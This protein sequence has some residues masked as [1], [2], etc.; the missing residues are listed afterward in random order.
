MF[1]HTRVIPIRL[2]RFRFAS[3]SPLRVT[4]FLKTFSIEPLGYGREMLPLHPKKNNP[5]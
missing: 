1:D 2:R 5:N 4:V 3:P